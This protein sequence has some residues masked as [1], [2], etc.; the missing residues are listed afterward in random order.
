VIRSDARVGIVV[1]T[2]GTRPE[3]LK[4]CISSIRLAS[5]E[6]VH[7]CLVAPK[8]VLVDQVD[9]LTQGDTFIQDPSRG[10]AT[11]INEGLQS[12][13]SNIEFINW[14]G[15]DDLLKPEAIDV[16]REVLVEATDAPFVFGRCEYIDESGRL[17]FTNRAGAWA[18]PLM[19]FG[20]QLVPQPGALIRRSSLEK[21]GY[22][23][24][25]RNWAFDL[26]LFLRLSR[27]GRPRAVP[28][29]LAAFRWHNDSLSVGSRLGSVNEASDV[30]REHLHRALKPFSFLWEPLMRL[31]ILKI[32]G[33]VS[34]Q[35]T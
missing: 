2:L 27:L 18:V 17:L 3:F 10:L 12:F 20:P 15:D 16:A 23:D 22:L 8:I 30:R 31:A 1:P 9:V 14:L 21:A 13:P 29:T 6:P 26:D 25:Q 32:G 7:I 11:A 5:S 19:R 35:V 4:E 28:R 34:R 24:P 33:L